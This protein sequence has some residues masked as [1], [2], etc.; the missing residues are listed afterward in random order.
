MYL[1]PRVIPVL[2]IEDDCLVKTVRFN[3]RI[4]IGDPINAVRIFNVEEADE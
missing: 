1:K 4:Y 2:L 3:K